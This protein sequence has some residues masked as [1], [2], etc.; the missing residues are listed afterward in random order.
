MGTVSVV[1]VLP[2]WAQ[3]QPLPPC[4]VVTLLRFRSVVAR[5][6]ES[7]VYVLGEFSS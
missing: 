5:G 1:D 7:K 2:V 6:K 3:I 4:Y